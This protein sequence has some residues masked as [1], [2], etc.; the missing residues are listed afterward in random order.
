MEK[1]AWG[2]NGAVERNSF[3]HGTE[4]VSTVTAYRCWIEFGGN[5]G[6]GKLLAKFA[7]APRS[8]CVELIDDAVDRLLRGQEVTMSISGMMPLRQRLQGLGVG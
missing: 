6:N 8:H 2:M 1:L 7:P 4:Q 5:G 3:M